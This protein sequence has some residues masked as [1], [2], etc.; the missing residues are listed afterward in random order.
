[1]V[2]AGDPATFW[3]SLKQGELVLGTDYFWNLPVFPE[4]LP[5]QSNRHE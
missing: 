1:V 2:N 3:R 5:D 4:L